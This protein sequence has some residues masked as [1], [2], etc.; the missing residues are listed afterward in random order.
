MHE[1]SGWTM[2]TSCSFDE[3]EN[4]LDYYRE[5]GITV[6][7]HNASYDTHFIINQL[8]EEFKEANLIV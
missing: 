3:K 4:K 1:P 8:V 7:I 2:F 5:K 6:I